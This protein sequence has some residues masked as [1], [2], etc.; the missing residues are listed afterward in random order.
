[1][2]F[3]GKVYKHRSHWLAEVPLFEA[4]TQGRS[5]QEALEMIEDWFVSMVD[6]PGFSVKALLTERGEFELISSHL[7]SMISLLLQR[8]RHM[9]GLSLADAAERLGAKS[10]NAYARYERGASVPTIEKLDELLKAVSPDRDFVL[11]S[12]ARSLAALGRTEE[13]LHSTRRR[14]AT[15]PSK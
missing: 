9:S 7:A 5:R 2:R 13:G 4:M 8:Q 11:H 10:R 14:R 1:M 3:S 12:S 15:G 6:R